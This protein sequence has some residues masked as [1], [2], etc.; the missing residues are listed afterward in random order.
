M[1]YLRNGFYLGFI[2]LMLLAACGPGTPTAMPT[3]TGLV[4]KKPLPAPNVLVTVVPPVLAFVC[5]PPIPTVGEVSSSCANQIKGV[6]GITYSDMTNLQA[7]GTSSWLVGDSIA[8]SVSCT[9]D[10]GTSTATCSG[11]Q[12]GAFQAMVCSSCGDTT[13]TNASF[14]CANGYNKS[15]DGYCYATDAKKNSPTLWCPA[16]S[17]YD[18][19]LQNCADNV[20]NKLASPCPS[21]YPAYTPFDHKCWNKAEMAFNCQTFPLQLGACTTP[22]KVPMSVVPFCQNNDANIGGANITYPAGS[23][24]T[25]DIKSNHLDSCTPGGTQPD[26]TQLFTCLG[27]GGGTFDAK[28]CTDPASCSTTKET[29]GTC[30]GKNN[31]GSGPGPAPC[32][33]NRGVTCP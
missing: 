20:T 17:H 13:G 30:A 15:V 3:S 21:G 2:L 31:Q 7:D 16:G 19:A 27:T 32:I 12:N 8:G 10:N 14:V 1:K 4:N 9:L 23:S 24:L 5:T 29:L 6:G 26:G 22:K 11:A 28:L 25:V 33:P 18:N